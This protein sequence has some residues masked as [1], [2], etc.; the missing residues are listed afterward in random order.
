MDSPSKKFEAISA[1]KNLKGYKASPVRRVNI[2]KPNGKLRPLGIPTIRDRIIQT[3]FSFALDPIAE[4]TSD[5]R[6][7]G[8]RPYRGVND[9]AIYLK[10]VLGSYTATRRFVLDADI[11]GF[12]DSVGHKWLLS[13]I[14]MNKDILKEF[15][16]A[17]F[18]EGTVFHETSLG[19]PQGSPISPV[20]ANMALNGLQDQIGKEFL[21]TRY[22]DDFLVLGKSEQDLK[23]SAMPSILE[24]LKPRGLRLNK[25]KTSI[26]EISKGFN[27]LGFHFREYTDKNR[28]KGTKKGILLVKPSNRNIKRLKRVISKLVHEH[29]NKPIHMLI[30]S[31]N[32]KL[33]GW[34]EHYRTVTSQEAFN[35]ISYHLWKVCWAMLRRKHRRRGAAWIRE[36]YFTKVDGN[37]WILCSKNKEGE[38][39]I[40]LFQI[41]YVDIKR[42]TLCK[43]LNPYDPENYDYF[44]KRKA[45]GARM[46]LLLGKVRTSLLRKQ[47]GDCPV[48]K[49][50]LL[51]GEEL[52][53]HHVKPRVSGGSDKL[54]NLILLHKE[55]HKQVTNSKDEKLLALWKSENIIP[56]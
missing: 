34:S 55:C 15:L 24:F 53:V 54:S 13:N 26:S 4:E 27:Y 42:H 8:F 39:E 10:L 16:S 44:D 35:S 56:K 1:V 41:S 49:S 46:S 36:K 38:V 23:E 32:M 50:T 12:F 37:K 47:K 25:N 43:T 18:V 31:L 30:Q 21:F 19:F 52:E 28:V 33:R 14:P 48:C 2:P 11:E 5:S 29:R 6:S 51:N 22:A 9:N 45:G 7:Y 40:K 17:G 20:L 3:L